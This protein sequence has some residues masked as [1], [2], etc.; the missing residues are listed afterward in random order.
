MEFKKGYSRQIDEQFILRISKQ[1]SEEF[2][3]L[4]ELNVT[5]HGEA[6][7]DY[8]TKIY[9]E[10][11]KKDQL[12]WLYIEDQ[13]TQ[14]IVSSISLMPYE[15]H[16]G[17][18]IIPICEMGFVGSLQEYRGKGFISKLNVLYEQVMEERGYV[19]S[20]IRGIQFFYR[21]LGYEF[22]IP[23]DHRILLSPSKIPRKKQDNL[24]IRRVSHHE[25]DKVVKMYN[26]TYGNYFIW[27]VFDLDS[28]I[29]R[30]FNQEFNDFLAD[31]YFIEENGQPVSYFTFGKS[32]D[33]L[34]YE[35]KTSKLSDQQ[36]VKI[37]QCVEEYHKGASAEIDLSIRE[38]TD[39]AN[40]AIQIGGKPYNS[41]GWQVK[42][43][44]LKLFFEKIKITL[45]ERINN[46]DFRALNQTFYISNYE[47]TVELIF[48]EGKITE[49]DTRE[50]YPEVG[51]CDVAIPGAFLFKLLL[52]DRTF[53]ELKFIVPDAMVKRESKGLISTLFP[54]EPSFPES[55]Y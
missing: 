2:K 1:G 47:N 41:Y 7:R 55:Y 23:L 12:F 10:H 31:L 17:N 20:V 5:V 44:D 3:K 9:N 22:A 39:L 51:A 6:V 50:G 14:K 21:K 37:L 53:D 40:Y 29:F 18:V 32:Y 24:K 11:P 33:N 35:F 49:I 30:Y 42:I 28:Y 36:C 8:I 16:F 38:E 43:P 48:K 27:T 52:G 45:E 26:E 19:V 15:W 46:S 4:L 34:G 13:K 25:L 54:K